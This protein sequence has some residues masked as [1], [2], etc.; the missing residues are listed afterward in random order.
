M[1]RLRLVDDS[2]LLQI[3][4][5]SAGGVFGRDPEAEFVVDHPTVSRRHAQFASR[6][7]DIELLDLGSANGTLVNGR[8][9]GQRP[10]LLEHGDQL[11]FGGM[12]AS[13]HSASGDSDSTLQ[14]GPTARGSRN[15]TVVTGGNLLE[16]QMRLGRL[17][18]RRMLVDR[19]PRIPGYELGHVLLPAMGV[20]GDFIYWGLAG[21]GRHVLA[22]GDV[23]GKGVAAAMYMA[24]VSGM[25]VQIV[26]GEF[27]ALGILDRANRALHPIMEPGMFVTCCVMLVD[28]VRHRMEL[29]CA[30]HAPPV[31]RHAAGSAADVAIA[32]GLPLGLGAQV[33][34]G[35]TELAL[36]PGDL[37]TVITD[38]VDEAKSPAGEEF[39]R[40][41]VLDAIGQGAGAVDTARRLQSAVNRHAA[42]TPQHDDITLVS[43]ERLA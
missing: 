25:L 9:L 16:T 29:G 8:A 15:A 40:W 35:S 3:F 34:I 27:S 41:R 18:Q 21:D 36:A 20:G 10:C 6:N 38:G 28:P 43:V 24:Y 22:V 12:L 37:L 13:F 17:A 14:R 26:P 31:I 4:D 2:N 1:A 11:Q 33:D 23:C 7:G 32:P 5:L 19:P 30:G 39:S 42:G